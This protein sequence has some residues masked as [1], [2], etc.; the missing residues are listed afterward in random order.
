MLTRAMTHVIPLFRVSTDALICKQSL[1]TQLYYIEIKVFEL[2]IIIIII[3][4]FIII[5]LLYNTEQD[6]AIS[7][8]MN[9]RYNI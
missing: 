2:R 8:D 5:I 4:I 6:T 9:R 7:G 3:I 1:A